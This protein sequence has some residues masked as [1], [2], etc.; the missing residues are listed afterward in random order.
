MINDCAKQ[1][2][3]A[4]RSGV[5]EQCAGYMRFGDMYDVLGVACDVYAKSHPSTSWARPSDESPAY[6]FLERSWALPTEVKEW[7]KLSDSLG[8]FTVD[9]GCDH[10][11]ADLSDDG[12]TFARLADFIESAPE[13]LFLA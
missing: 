13:G 5:Y 3:E 11:L 9:I 1:W 7:L 8:G 6:A 10:C 12:W 2:V 4:L